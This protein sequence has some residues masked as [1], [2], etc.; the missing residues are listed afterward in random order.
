[1]LSFIKALSYLMTVYTQP[2]A[3]CYCCSK[4]V[5]AIHMTGRNEVPISL[6]AVA[7]YPPIDQAQPE[8]TR[9]QKELHPLHPYPLSIN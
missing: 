5:C 1:M 6:Q 4:Y 9:T 8:K 7:R 3:L 2:I